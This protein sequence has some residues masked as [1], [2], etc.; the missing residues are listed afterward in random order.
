MSYINSNPSQVP[1]DLVAELNKDKIDNLIS[2]IHMRNSYEL[3]KVYDWL[4]T[5]LDHKS[6]ALRYKLENLRKFKGVEQL[7]VYQNWDFEKDDESIDFNDDIRHKY[8]LQN[9]IVSFE[10]IYAVNEQIQDI[11]AWKELSG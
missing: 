10:E 9:K 3:A 8:I 4:Y 7:P 6:K 2:T 5:V 1:G 11:N